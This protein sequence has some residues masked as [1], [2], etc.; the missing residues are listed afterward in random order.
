MS[1]IDPNSPIPKYFQIARC[2]ATDYIQNKG[3][4]EDF[5]PSIPDLAKQYGV[6]KATV[7]KSIRYLKDQDE[8]YSEKGRK[9]YIKARQ[10]QKGSRALRRVVLV[11]GKPNTYYSLLQG[12][13]SELAREYHFE[14][15]TVHTSGAEAEK[16]LH[17]QGLLN[18]N[19]ETGYIVTLTGFAHRHLVDLLRE[20]DMPHVIVNNQSF[21]DS[22][23]VGIDNRKGAEKA[24]RALALAGHRRIAFLGAHTQE[25]IPRCER[26]AGYQEALR[27]FGCEEDDQ[28]IFLNPV[29]KRTAPDGY[30]LAMSAL[31][32]GVPFT[33]CLS[34][35]YDFLLGALLAAKDCGRQV[36]DDL[37]LVGFDHQ[38]DRSA[39]MVPALAVVSYSAHDLGRLAL[40]ALLG[41]HKAELVVPRVYMRKSIKTIA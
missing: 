27:R 14:L 34:L 10:Q 19:G 9:T 1:S 15:T 38:R 16:Y 32:S 11:G 24:V 31:T 20:G 23:T 33:A 40:L 35:T 2:I 36:P 17:R 7:E 18:G 30:A 21:P 8:V 29:D 26:L 12:G 41:N 6:A 22:P 3:Y 37:S 25:D 5:L 13:I 39:N 4:P 28:L